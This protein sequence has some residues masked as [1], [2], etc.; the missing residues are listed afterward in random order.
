MAVEERM[1]MAVEDVEGIPLREGV[2]KVVDM[3]PVHHLQRPQPLGR[4]HLVARATKLGARK[5]EDGGKMERAGGVGAYP[6]VDALRPLMVI[7]VR[8]DILEAE[9]GAAAREE[10]ALLRTMQMR[11]ERARGRRAR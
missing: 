7:R 5:A 6:P 4:H 11:T 2:D 10:E 8:V 1:A 9:E 3:Y